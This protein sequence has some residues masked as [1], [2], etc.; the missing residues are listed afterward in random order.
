M[1]PTPQGG[2]LHDLQ[3][4]ERLVAF[5]LTM[6]AKRSVTQGGHGLVTEQK[7]KCIGP[8]WEIFHQPSLP[9]SGKK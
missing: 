5:I 2:D 8:H 7:F 1:L 6:S 9:S 4:W 3:V